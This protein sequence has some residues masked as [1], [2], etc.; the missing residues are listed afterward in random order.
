ME[1]KIF[2]NLADINSLKGYYAKTTEEMNLLIAENQEKLSS[3]P[4]Y[5]ELADFFYNLLGY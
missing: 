2:I 4:D 5:C 1:N 3:C